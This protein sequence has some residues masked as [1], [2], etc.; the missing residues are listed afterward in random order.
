VHYFRHTITPVNLWLKICTKSSN[1][2]LR[3]LYWKRLSGNVDD[4]TAGEVLGE[5]LSIESSA[6]QD[7]SQ[8]CSSTA[9]T[10]QINEQKVRLHTALVDLQRQKCFHATMHLCQKLQLKVHLEKTQPKVEYGDLENWPAKQ[11]WKY[12]RSQKNWIYKI[13]QYLAKIWTRVW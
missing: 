7:H 3:Y 12:T 2:W 4:W 1:K 6:H 11:N 9:E 13:G 5:F 8:V 10:L